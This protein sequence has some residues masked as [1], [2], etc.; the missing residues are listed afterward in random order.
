[1]KDNQRKKLYAVSNAHLDTQW[2]WTIKDTIRDC[3]KNTMEYNF[4]L[5]EKYP[6]Y[7]FNFEGAFRYKLMKEY[8]PELYEKVKEYVAAGRWV[9]VGGAWDSM[10]VN[11]PSSESLMRQVLYGN[12]FFEKEFGV[13]TEDIFLPDCFGFRW[14][15][16]SIASHMGLIGFSTQKLV[17][18]VGSPMVGEDGKLL[19][20]MV[21][22]E[23][24]R[25]DLAKWR[26]PDGNEVFTSF[27]SGNYTYNFDKDNDERPL[28]EREELEKLIDNNGKYSGVYARNLYFGTGDY[29]GSCSDGSARLL[30]DAVNAQGQGDFDVISASPTQIYHDLTEEEAAALPV[31]EGGL[32]IPHGYGA[33]TS[34]TAMKR[35]NRQNEA[36]ADAA[37]RSS[38]V[39]AVFTGA[40]YPKEKL[41]KAWQNFL[42]H[43]FH[44]D[45]TGTSIADA[46]LYSHNDMVISG[47]MFAKETEAS[48]GKI[49][50]MLDTMCDGTPVVVYNPTALARREKITAR[51]EE[52]PESCC[53]KTKSG[54]YLPTYSYKE[55]GYTYVSFIADLEPVSVEAFEIADGEGIAK[56]GL[57]IDDRS[58]ENENLK[59]TVN[60]K[61]NIAS[62][63][64]KVLGKELL[65]A[66]VREELYEDNSTVWPSWEYEFD[67]LM[68]EPR[69]LDGEVSIEKIDNSPVS[70]GFKIVIKSGASTYTKTL[71]L[72]DG[73]KGL[74]L[75]CET[76][77]QE[78]ASLLMMR[79]PL[80]AE[81]EK[82]LFDGDL[83][84]EL[85]GNTNEYPYF[86][87]N[88]HK[89]AD[90]TDKSGQYGVT[91][92]NDCKYAAS[93]P[94]DNTLAFVLIH[95]PIANFMPTSGQDFQDLGCNK[96]S[97]YIQGHEGDKAAVNSAAALNNKLLA[98]KVSKHN[99]ERSAISFVDQLPEGVELRAIKKAED[100]D[101]IIVRIQESHGIEHKG[102]KLSF[103]GCKVEKAVAC[104]GYETEKAP[105]E[106]DGKSVLFDIGRYNVM[107]LKLTLSCEAAVEA[108]E[109]YKTVLLDYNRDI[110]CSAG[111][112]KEAKGVY[113]PS[114][115]YPEKLVS[116]GVEYKLSKDDCNVVVAK[117]Q[118][119]ALSPE[120]TKARILCAVKKDSEEVVFKAGEKEVKIKASAFTGFAG[121]R[122]MVVNG[123]GNANC[124]DEIAFVLT[125]TRDEKG[126]DK[127]YDFAYIY[128][129]EIDTKG[130]DCLTLPD[131]EDLLVFAVTQ[132]KSED[133]KLCRDIFD[134]LPGT[135]NGP[136]HKL[137]VKGI[138]GAGGEYRS[139]AT[140]LLFAPKVT[141]DGIFDHFEGEGILSTDG[142]YALV[143]M[144]DHDM[145]VE[146][147][148]NILGKNIAEG[149]PCSANHEMNRRE[150]AEKALDGK[151]H[152]KW[153]GN[154]DENGLCT[155]TVD[156]EGVYEPKSYLICHAGGIESKLW[157]T[158][159]FDILVKEKEEDEFVV[160]DSVRDN[161]EDLTNRALNCGKVRY[162]MLKITNPA[163]D[164]DTHARIYHF[165]LFE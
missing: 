122:E 1:M 117:G 11:V 54:K 24:P 10:D 82:A 124:E 109:E 71:T 41:D 59:V 100:S 78:R 66:P 136:K 63:Y 9:P 46:Y 152:T 25:V 88:V 57:Y 17:W 129:Y 48:V 20:P 27:L 96:Y 83:G 60:D 142:S 118:K 153:C 150:S 125:H 15:L 137:K 105:A 101:D 79:F 69:V 47:N 53:V 112:V 157:N 146:A 28:K 87:H 36:A 163:K 77:W 107:T 68:K 52:A 99:G 130:C 145:T 120:Y 16:P 164:G 133:V 32:L 141:G 55:G 151:G 62:I 126:E 23:L 37:E 85:C 12:K 21:N 39:A 97:F 65:S 22:K 119:I 162:V 75:D 76:D 38:V 51:L 74:R 8:Y 84:A 154:R 5:F 86:I 14:A 158:V 34:H 161:T 156:L 26:G 40:R 131:N 106:T 58:I 80:S 6:S 29:G 19:K 143:K 49:A 148:Y 33:M 93:K 90:L 121:S 103:K 56:C 43:Q 4:K 50:E 13:L 113:I 139:G 102:V 3:V 134:S 160:A 144:A 123:S 155:L 81:N 91:V 111:Q 92:S 44:D 7:K 159:D 67:D 31:Y 30:E 95:T 116:A 127:L 72:D 132:I 18:G 135:S 35:L 89:W 42:W 128:A 104:N 73:A 108:K 115:L 140:V 61:G 94:D 165:G 149:K 98:Y 64:D 70:V 110:L 2:N 138:K 45:I 147:V 114:E